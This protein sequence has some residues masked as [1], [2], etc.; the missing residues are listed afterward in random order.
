MHEL[1]SGS[2]CEHFVK[3]NLN[4]LGRLCDTSS[5]FKESK[6]L[7]PQAIKVEIVEL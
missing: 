1:Q 5:A 3:L 7:V 4:M 2:R 6:L